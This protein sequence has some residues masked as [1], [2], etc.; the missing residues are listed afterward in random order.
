MSRIPAPSIN[1]SSIPPI[2][3]EP[4]IATAPSVTRQKINTTYI[5]TG[6]AFLKRVKKMN[7][8]LIF[9]NWHDLAHNSQDHVIIHISLGFDLL[10]AAKMAPV[11][12]PLVIEFQ[13][14]SLPLTLTSPQS[15]MEKRPPHTAKLPNNQTFIYFKVKP[16]CVMQAE[17]EKKKKTIQK[18]IFKK[19]QTFGVRFF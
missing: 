12:A 19:N 6:Y 18:K 11:M 9:I 17:N 7:D 10:L 13:G 3:A 5:N 8:L 16:R 2:A 15:I 4:T 14:S 1:A